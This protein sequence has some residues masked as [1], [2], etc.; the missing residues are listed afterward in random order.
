MSPKTWLLNYP[1]FSTVT[2]VPGAEAGVQN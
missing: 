2:P 1:E